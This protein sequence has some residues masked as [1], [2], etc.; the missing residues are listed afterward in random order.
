MGMGG[1]D[2]YGPH[3]YEIAAH[4]STSKLP[5]AAMGSG[6]L[7]AMSVLEGGWKKDLEEADAKQLVRNAIA[8]GI[9]N[10]MGSGSNVDL[11][12]I[13]ANDNVQYLRG[14][15]LA[16]VKGERKDKYTVPKGTTAVLSEKMQKIKLGSRGEGSQ[17][18]IES[19][20]V[21][22]VEAMDTV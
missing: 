19:E 20:T 22:Q 11:V 8:A 15:D 17:F 12:V 9:F 2:K 14:F 7:P 13:K 21:R 16:N 4:G 6:T 3:L 5:F 18:V 1:V 10:D